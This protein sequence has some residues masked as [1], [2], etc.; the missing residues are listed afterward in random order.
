MNIV[1]PEDHLLAEGIT[2]ALRGVHDQALDR[3]GSHDLQVK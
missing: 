3:H 1:T 2:K